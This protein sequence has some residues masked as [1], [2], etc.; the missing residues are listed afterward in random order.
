M[1]T[2]REESAFISNGFGPCVDLSVRLDLINQFTCSAINGP[3]RCD[4]LKRTR[5]SFVIIE[6]THNKVGCSLEQQQQQ[7][8]LTSFGDVFIDWYR[9]KGGRRMTVKIPIISGQPIIGMWM[10]CL[11]LSIWI[12]ETVVNT[13]RSC[14]DEL[15]EL[16]GPSSARIWIS[17][18][19]PHARPSSHRRRIENWGLL[20]CST[21][22]LSAEVE[23]NDHHEA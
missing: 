2:S 3:L 14:P 10:K 17:H 16:D 19:E 6:R 4:W 5:E 12:T 11:Q 23:L 18:C 1:L 15:I 7:P 21:Y 13:L 8:K 9:I 22:L 20:L